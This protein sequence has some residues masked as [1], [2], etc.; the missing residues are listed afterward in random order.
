MKEIG[1]EKKDKKLLKPMIFIYHYIN[2]CHFKILKIEEISINGLFYIDERAIKFT[3]T[4]VFHEH[5]CN[6][7]Y[8]HITALHPMLIIATPI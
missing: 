5:S 1:G 6:L 2:S 8:I 3:G 7:I 4:H